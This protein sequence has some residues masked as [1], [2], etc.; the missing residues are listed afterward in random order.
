MT[1]LPTAADMAATTDG[2]HVVAEIRHRRHPD[3]TFEVE[4][5]EVAG[6]LVTATGRWVRRVGANYAERL[7]RARQ[8]YAWT[9]AEPLEIRYLG[10]PQ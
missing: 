6:Q 1:D 7:V 10:G 8:T 2:A 3:E 9:T 4:T 5:L